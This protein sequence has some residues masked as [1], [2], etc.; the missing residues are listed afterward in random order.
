MFETSCHI[1]RVN[2]HVKR[3]LYAILGNL[4]TLDV[5]VLYIKRS[6]TYDLFFIMPLTML[7]RDTMHLVC[8]E[9]M[10]QNYIRSHQESPAPNNGAMKNTHRGYRRKAHLINT[11]AMQ[12]YNRDNPLPAFFSL[13]NSMDQIKHP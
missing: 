6:Y 11:Y 3:Y 10:Q 1:D 7:L 12:Q 8:C 2:P 5:P 9:L 13:S 4:I